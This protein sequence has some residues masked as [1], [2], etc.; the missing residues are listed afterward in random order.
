MKIYTAS[1]KGMRDQN[2]DMHN[3]LIN[4][5]GKNKDLKK[6]ASMNYYAVY[7]GHGGKFVSKFLHDNLPQCFMDRRME[8]P[9]K[10]TIVNKIY[11]YWQDVLK[12]K[13]TK[14]SANIGSTCLIVTHHKTDTNNEYLNIL[15]TGDSRAMICRGEKGYAL[16]QDHKPDWPEEHKRIKELGGNIVFDGYDW[17]IKDYS[18]SRAFGDTSAEPFITYM[19]D[20]YKYNITQNDKFIVLACDGLWD[21]CSLQDVVNFI[22]INCYDISKKKIIDNHEGIDIAKKIAKMA[23]D[24]GSTD[25]VTVIV[26]FL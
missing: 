21:V 8:Y 12:T 22:F 11:A 1:L 7:D 9:L 6:Y 5:D 19:P 13:H 15:N 14:F 18:V 2:E 24:K 26:V 16:T 20:I 4:M 25:N 23:I 3:V 10:K 17:R